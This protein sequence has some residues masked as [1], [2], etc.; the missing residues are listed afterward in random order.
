MDYDRIKKL[1]ADHNYTSFT[2][3]QEDTFSNPEAFFNRN[4]FII[5]QTSTGKTLIPVLLY[6]QALREAEEAGESKPKMLFAVPYRA[7][8]AQKMQELRNFFKGQG[9]Q[10]VQSTGEFRQDDEAIMKA[11]VDIAVII[12]EKAFK[13]QARDERFFS[14]YDYLILDEVGLVDS[15]ERGIRLDFLFAWAHNSKRQYGQPRTISLATPFYDW[16]AYVNSY[17]FC[18]VRRDDRPV[19]LKETDIIYTKYSIL[20]V[21]KSDFIRPI[22]MESSQRVERVKQKHGENAAIRCDFVNALCP[23]QEPARTDKN[24]ICPFLP[25]SCKAGLEY[26]PEGCAPGLQYILL[27][28]CREHLKRGHQILIFINDREQVKILCKFLYQQLRDLLPI[29]PNPEI[30]RKEVLSKSGLEEDDVFGILESGDGDSLDM[31]FYEAFTAGI[32]FHSAALPNEL[33]AYVEDRFLNSQEMRIVCSTETLA[34]G[35]NSAVDVVIL[36]ALKK[37]D[38][39]ESRFLTMNEFRNYAGRA[40]RMRQGLNPEEAIGYVYTLIPQSLKEKWEEVR[41]SEATPDQLHSR[42]HRDDG[43]QLVFSLLN[44]L[45]DNDSGGMTVQELAQLLETLPQDG[46]A[47]AEQLQ[48]KVG[49]ALEFLCNQELATVSRTRFRGRC[50]SDN[51]KRYCLTAGRGARLRGFSIDKED[52]VQILQALRENSCLIFADLDSITFLYRLLQTKHAGQGLNT[53]YSKSE[54]RLSISELRDAIRSRASAE[55]ELVWLDY[56][57]DEKLLSILAAMLAWCNGE[58]AK[59]LYRQYG[60]HYALLDKIAV[61]ISYLIEI[62]VEVLPFHMEKIWEENTELYSRMK[63]DVETFVNQVAKKSEKLH[64]LFIS[65]YF[66]VNTDITREYLEFLLSKQEPAAQSL[67]RE[68]SLDS[69][70]PKSARVLRKLAMF[71]LFFAKSPEENP[72]DTVAWHNYCSQ[73]RQYQLDVK[74]RMG[75]YAEEFFCS[76]FRTFSD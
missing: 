8:A 59:S 10:I 33:R 67:A 45:P 40:G 20:D 57:D 34:F 68:L 39:G 66:G 52:Y 25:S 60:I 64:D 30:C 7:L 31:E 63:L 13:Y 75:P 6:A 51:Q 44:M 47:T 24:K 28:L 17:D 11:Q 36:A 41:Q 76:R 74:N 29:T 14:Q 2:A 12:T 9:L 46:S 69:L 27:K 26:L 38:G 35:V 43:H 4:L 19:K 65:V 22:R 48:R 3:L 55:H 53:I 49:N 61:Q 5:S 23:I 37:Q 42:L 73:R 70:N 71:Y 50:A 62:A 16:S 58:S 18:V 32:G 72:T 54:T 56:C 1:A 21:G 15:A